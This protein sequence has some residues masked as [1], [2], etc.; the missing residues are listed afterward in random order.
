MLLKNISIS[1]S[2]KEIFFGSSV[3][4]VY[5]Y[6]V[7]FIDRHRGGYS[8]GRRGA[9]ASGGGRLL[10]NGVGHK[11]LLGALRADNVLAVGDESLA[12]H[13]RLHNHTTMHQNLLLNHQDFW[14]V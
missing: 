9:A 10:F 6:T 13:R 11:L 14:S 5:M 1:R 8:V 4:Y 12:H 3:L 7:S 2:P